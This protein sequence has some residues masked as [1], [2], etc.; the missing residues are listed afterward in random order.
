[1]N[2]CITWI[3][4]GIN[5]EPKA[6]RSRDDRCEASACPTSPT[7]LLNRLLLAEQIPKPMP[8]SA[9]AAKLNQKQ[10]ADRV[11]V[12]PSRISR[13]TKDGGVVQGRYVPSRDAVVR[14]SDGKLLGYE[15]PVERDVSRGDVS[16]RSAQKAAG[17]G[18][19]GS[20]SERGGGHRKN[21]R[22][23]GGTR[24]NERGSNTRQGQ[25]QSGGQAQSDRQ[26]KSDRQPQSDGLEEAIDRASKSFG[27]E[28]ARR[29]EGFHAVLRLGG[30]ALGAVLGAEIGRGAVPALVGTA[31]GAGLV[32]ISIRSTPARPQEPTR[33]IEGLSL[34]AANVPTAGLPAA[35]LPAAGLPGRRIV[36][37]D[38]SHVFAQSRNGRDAQ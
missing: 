22:A 26:T 15:E 24:S 7:A 29:P 37:P 10:Y 18:S 19:R 34:P 12:T 28:A 3:A 30:A 8:D 21:G 6:Y 4:G 17:N 31:I 11:G 32:E 9:P 2:R 5:G 38:F 27:Q 16:A 36:P 33:Q 25:P 1:M 14:E 20:R 13:A 35:G 23:S